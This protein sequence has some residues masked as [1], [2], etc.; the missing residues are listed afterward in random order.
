LMNSKQF[1]HLA[2]CPMEGGQVPLFGL[3]IRLCNSHKPRVAGFTHLSEIH[4]ESA[5]S[6]G[7]K[8]NDIFKMVRI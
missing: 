8:V 3:P 6:E 4:Y 5:C 2:G 7:R 1:M